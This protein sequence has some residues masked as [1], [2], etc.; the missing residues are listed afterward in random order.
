M[1]RKISLGITLVL[2]ISMLQISLLADN[3]IGQSNVVPSWKVANSC[4]AE[5]QAAPKM[6]PAKDIVD[7]ASGDERFTTLT[8]ALNE[9]GLVEVLKGQGPFTV[10]APTNDA[11]AKLPA[12][13]LED[14]LK[15]ENKE[16]L[17]DLLRY[18][19]YPGK[20]LAADAQKL[21]GKEITMANGDKAKVE[22]KDG[23]LYIDGAKVI[24]T[25]I[26]AKNGVIHVIDTVMMP[27]GD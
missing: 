3:R 4:C 15:P 2:I 20:V 12:G 1:K 17:A 21:N 18:H 24:A 7:I 27:S 23:A 10:F 26:I 6:L 9:A 5:V 8:A 13:T 25:D 22:L 19:V 14:L 11:F 16:M